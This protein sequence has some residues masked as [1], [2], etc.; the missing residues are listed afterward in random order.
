MIVRFSAS[1][2]ADIQAIYDFIAQENPKIAA[3][4]IGTIEQSTMRLGDFPLSGR[5]GV[6]ETTRE[7]VIPRL[8]YIAVYRLNFETIEVIAVFHAAQDKPRNS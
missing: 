3:R 7:L 6:V 4:V 5:S 2:R 8:P 1:A